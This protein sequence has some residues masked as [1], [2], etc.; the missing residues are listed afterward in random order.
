MTVFTH[1][2]VH[3]LAGSI[4][5]AQY[6]DP[7]S[8]ADPHAQHGWATV[9]RVLCLAVLFL[10]GWRVMFH[11]GLTF[12]AVAAILACP[13]WIG[14][15]RRYRSGALLFA[16]GGV[17][18]LSGLLLTAFAKNQGRY[19]TL[20]AVA[21]DS[22][23]WIG[24]FVGIGAVLWARTILGLGW[25]GASYGLGMLLRN[26]THPD[27]LAPT[28]P[29]K[30]TF[31]LPLT[32]IALAMVSQRRSRIGSLMVLLALGAASAVLDSRSLFG[33]LL[34]AAI[35][36]G[37]QLRPTGSARPLA[38]GWTLLLL[39]GL[40]AG[41]YNLAT[42]L[43]L[44]GYLGTAVELRSQQQVQTAGSLL[45]GGR[46]EIA[47]SIALITH[48]PW[49]FGLGVGPTIFDVM[50]A[51]G[52]MIKLNY[53]PDNG[54]VEHYM[55][56]GHV[57]LHSTIGDLWATFGIP[58]MLFAIMI[59]LLVIRGLAGSLGRRDG[60]GL[61]LFLACDTLWNLPFSPLYSSVP[62]LVLALG[63]AL[64]VAGRQQA[65]RRAL[66]AGRRPSLVIDDT[67]ATSAP[68]APVAVKA[69]KSRV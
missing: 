37:W 63:L 5:A 46:P 22:G 9:E 48:T 15:V 44:D 56:G 62:T 12:G 45:L 18:Y 66:D 26:L 38:W 65:P 8:A 42:S 59:A 19:F 61:L 1:P 39:C 34:L 41:V 20:T 17:V 2:A 21:A 11:K 69:R 51:K 23:L 50:T 3:R 60:N 14:V 68:T 36:V 29:W 54:Y 43:M 40:A 27:E 30:W 24:I 28:N 52:G 49:G 32:I 58:G 4:V 10:L 55:F 33:T 47:A 57:E 6:E 7:L 53:D 31:S 25:I 35:L 64:P 16:A 67:V 13:L